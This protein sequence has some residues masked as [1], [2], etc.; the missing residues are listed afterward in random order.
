MSMVLQL[1]KLISRDHDWVLRMTIDLSQSSSL[2]A[3]VSWASG[4]PFRPVTGQNVQGYSESEEPPSGER[5]YESVHCLACQSVHVVNPITGKL[6]S[7]E[8]DE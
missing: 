5:R 1:G 6:L 2:A 7:E 8:V 3:E 4:K